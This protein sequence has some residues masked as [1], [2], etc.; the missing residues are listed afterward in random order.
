MQVVESIQKAREKSITDEL[1]L[2]EIRKQNPEKEVFFKK[3]EE[4]G[5]TPKDILD[6]I[7]KQNAPAQEKP[8]PE[9]KTPLK[10]EPLKKGLSPFTKEKTES[11]PPAFTPPK[12][13]SVASVSAQE[14]KTVLTEEAQKKEEEMRA[15]FLKRVEAK[16][17]GENVEGDNFFY[18]PKKEIETSSEEMTE[19]MDGNTKKAPPKTIMIVVGLLL[20]GAVILLVLNFL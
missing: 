7:I 8:S 1:I 2:A 11:K 12:K 13:E 9:E 16:E 19:G 10:E 3:A 5:A 6:E 18:Q 4:R 14:G 17:R 20:L 15:Q